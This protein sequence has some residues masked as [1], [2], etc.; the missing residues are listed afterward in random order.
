D[1]FVE[2]VVPVVPVQ[3]FGDDGIL[4]DPHRSDV[5][6]VIDVPIDTVIAPEP[7]IEAIPAVDGSEPVDVVDAPI[8]PAATDDQVVEAHGI[9]TNDGTGLADVLLDT[10]APADETDAEVDAVAVDATTPESREVV[11]VAAPALVD[12]SLLT[13]LADRQ[14]QPDFATA[15]DPRLPAL[16]TPRAWLTGTGVA[17]GGDARAAHPEDAYLFEEPEPMPFFGRRV[18][19]P[20]TAVVAPAPPPTHEAPVSV[21]TAPDEAIVVV[22]D[23]APSQPPAPAVADDSFVDEE[24]DLTQLLEEL[25]QW[26]P[27]LPEPR[28]RPDAS[29]SATTSE[30]QPEAGAVPTVAPALVVA[31]TTPEEAPVAA[32]PEGSLLDS[33]GADLQPLETTAEEPA[34]TDAT[35]LVLDAAFADLQRAEDG[36]VV[37]EQQLAAGRVFLAAGLTSEAARSFE[38]ASSEPRTRFEAAE[39][40]ASLHHARGQ[41]FEAVQWFESAAAAPVPDAAVKRPVLYDLAESLEALGEP[42]RALGVLLDL[43]S[44][45]EDYRD[46][47]VRL[48]RLLRVDA[49]G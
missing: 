44:Q 49:G 33:T 14:G 47:R 30:V 45:V 12:T 4:T 23:D 3:A 9:D 7:V 15:G 40:L 41:L 35:G 1:V 24:I 29:V 46:A 26:D 19:P 13:V 10:S 21:A 43:L 34:E 18:A 48:D 36:R 17:S 42:D 5:A 28:R 38:R 39:A 32:E 25:K 31:T 37:A 16:S 22:T 2:V 27:V 8:E 6:P 20:V 11:A